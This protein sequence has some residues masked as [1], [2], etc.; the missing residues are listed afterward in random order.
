MPATKSGWTTKRISFFPLI[1]FSTYKFPGNL[2]QFIFSHQ[3]KEYTLATVIYFWAK[4]GATIW[5]IWNQ[6]L[7][8]IIKIYYSNSS[9][10]KNKTIEWIEFSRTTRGS[11]NKISKCKAQHHHSYIPG[12]NKIIKSVQSSSI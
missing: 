6:D 1:K 7:N 10:S 5:C 9:T 8:F 4:K 2:L 11:R 3:K 12:E